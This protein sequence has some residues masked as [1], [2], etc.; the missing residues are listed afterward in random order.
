MK[1]VS[2]VYK[3]M[4]YFI[5]QLIC[6]TLGWFLSC[7]YY[8]WITRGWGHMIFCFSRNFY[9][10]YIPRSKAAVS[11]GVSFLQVRGFCPFL[12]Y[13]FAR[14]WWVRWCCVS[15][16]LWEFMSLWD[17]SNPSRGISMVGALG[18][19]YTVPQSCWQYTKILIPLHLYRHVH[20]P[21]FYLSAGL[22][23]FVFFPNLDGIFYSTKVWCWQNPHFA[24]VSW[25]GVDV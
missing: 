23:C 22:F 18:S 11:R 1:P 16:M 12:A 7:G 14:W 20:F 17:R 21:T 13:H 6:W 5:S 25:F 3:S 2:C 9:F 4:L 19:C 10:A 24:S 8:E 15:H